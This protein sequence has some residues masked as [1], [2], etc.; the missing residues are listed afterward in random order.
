MKKLFIDTENISNYSFLEKLNLLETDEIT[1]FTS[2]NSKG[3]NG[4]NLHYLV[5]SNAK[6]E[7]IFL[8]TEGKNSL[9]FQMITH[10]GFVSAKDEENGVRNKCDYIIVSG[11]KGFLNCI[12]YF[13]QQFKYNNI[14]LIDD[15]NLENYLSRDVLVKEKKLKEEAILI[16]NQ[17]Y[18]IDKFKGLAVDSKVLKYIEK[19]FNVDILKIKKMLETHKG[20]LR[21]LHNAITKE[22]D[23]RGREIYKLL[24]KGQREISNL[25]KQNS[26]VL[27]ET[28]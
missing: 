17:K 8:K 21:D 20:N 24:K 4:V 3:L 2:N 6:I 15:L 27:K 12:S 18:Q 10:L 13:E 23:E 25:N 22:Y 7:S 19:T 9:D 1:L 16:E 28:L 5:N 26:K 11:D 14:Y